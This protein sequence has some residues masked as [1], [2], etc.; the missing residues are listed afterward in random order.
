MR[1][2][3]II[4]APS[5]AISATDLRIVNS[6]TLKPLKSQYTVTL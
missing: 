3:V 6:N 4:T 2:L 1:Q 5:N